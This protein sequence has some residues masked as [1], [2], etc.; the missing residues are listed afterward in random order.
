MGFV[1]RSITRI[2][3]NYAKPDG[4]VG[5]FITAGMNPGHAKVRRWGLEH[6]TGLR[7]QRIVELGCGGGAAVRD[8]L[9]RYPEATVTGVDHSDVAVA[10]TEKVNRGAITAGRA[11]AVLAAVTDL[12][13]DDGTFDLATAFETV[14]FWPGPVESFREVHRVLAPGGTFLVVNESDGGH[15]AEPVFSGIIEGIRFWTPE[16]LDGFLR[17]AGFANVSIDHDTDRH[18]VVLRAV[19]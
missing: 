18:R 5:T 11:T 10:M 16:E 13:F 4:P 19:K 1:R 2:F 7:P 12:P 17:E 8:L 3:T 9:R 14:Y 15:P 6:L